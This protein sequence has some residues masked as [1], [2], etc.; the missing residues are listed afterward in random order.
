MPL[1]GLET[2]VHQAPT[3]IVEGTKNLEVARGL[4]PDR[5]T[6]TWD[7]GEFGIEGSDWSPLANRAVTLLPGNDEMAEDM[8]QRIGEQLLHLGC[9][10]TFVDPGTLGLGA[11]LVSLVA[12]GKEA[13]TIVAWAQ[14][15]SYKLAPKVQL[16]PE[17]KKPP[18]VNGLREAIGPPPATR[19]PLKSVKSEPQAA[20]A[21]NEGYAAIPLDEISDEVRAQV[22]QGIFEAGAV[23][24]LAGSPNAGKTFFG[25]HLG[26]HVAAGAAWFG[27][28]VAQG[29]VIY[30]AAEAPGSVKTR[31]RLAAR[32]KF[33]GKRLP[34]YVVS[35]SPA[36]G[37]DNDHLADTGKLIA[38]AQWVSSTEGAA[39]RMIL[40]DTVA[41]VLGDG[42][43]N[44]DGMLRLAG[45]A[46][47]LAALT[48]AAVILVHHP[49]KSDPAGL[50]G[51]SSLQAA[52]DAILSIETDENT[53]I[54]TATL[55]KS[56]DSAAGRQ[57][58]FTLEAVILPTR[59]YFGDER[60]S[61][62]VIPK[63]VPESQRRRPKGKTQETLLIEL[64]R[65]HRGGETNWDKATIVKAGKG[66]GLHRN[67]A[68]H[69]LAGLIKAGFVSGSDASLSLR[70]PPEDQ[71]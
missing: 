32:T 53:G 12:D 34:F 21:E 58:F 29:P 9:D 69:A 24:V 40:I 67:S 65:R 3:L 55:V 33:E 43:E 8:M 47:Y 56:R 66:I 7:G 1:I 41:S 60:T 36:L 71:Q 38:T 13:A 42:E 17:P 50:R 49:S 64:E 11:D 2:L 62:V 4:W 30:V 27:A 5:P 63:D 22:V 28:K 16:E 20:E 35:A 23:G 25:I 54:R 57:I 19:T 44:A 45:S 10:V 14:E 46:K 37:S 51:H 31:A 26:V 6:L 52:V 61:C 18:A 70:H 15:H 68:A 39:V 59:D 48:D